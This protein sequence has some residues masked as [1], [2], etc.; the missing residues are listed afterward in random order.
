MVFGY[1]QQD[2]TPHKATFDAVNGVLKLHGEAEE[3]YSSR[4]HWVGLVIDC[5]Q[6]PG[7]ALVF[8]Q[9][10]GATEV[11]KVPTNAISPTPA[12]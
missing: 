9:H 10:K 6:C 4:R 3:E 11:V 5:E 2:K 7:G 12:Q 1:R 8:A